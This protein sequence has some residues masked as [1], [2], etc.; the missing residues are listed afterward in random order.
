[1]KM[2]T[3]LGLVVGA[4]LAVSAGSVWAAPDLVPGP[5]DS[6]A[7]WSVQFFLEPNHAA[8]SVQCI[9][10]RKTGG[11]VGEPNSG[12]WFFPSF[13]GWHGQWDPGGRS[14][15]VAWFH[16]HSLGHR[17]VRRLE[18]RKR[19]HRRFRPRHHSSWR[20]VVVRQLDHD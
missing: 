1:M 9:V 2:K 18:Q 17:R 3:L 8:G 5:I 19:M 6:T 20:H 12:T 10:F 11:V 7:E 13:A 16:V 14:R 15:E 4:V